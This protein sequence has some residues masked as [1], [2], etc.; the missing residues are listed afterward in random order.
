MNNHEFYSEYYKEL[1]MPSVEWRELSGRIKAENIINILNARKISTVL[2]IGAGTGSILSYLSKMDFATKYYALDISEEAINFI[3]KREDIIGL[4][5][6]NTY[7]G[8][9]L[10]YQDKQFDLVILSHVIE[11][12]HNPAE[13]LIEAARVTRYLVVE[14]PLED[15]LY[16]HIKINLFKSRYRE[17]TGHIQWFT[18]QKF[19]ILLCKTCNLNLLD[20]RMV[21]VPDSAYFFYKGSKRNIFNHLS[22]FIKKILRSIS[23]NI[24]SL[25]LT[26]HCIALVSD[27]KS[28]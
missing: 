1:S 27:L 6:A 24:Y 8:H 11:H 5:D 2:E 23:P 7:D 22:L 3:K 15:N 26:D 17:E 9:H 10:P 18:K 12:L 14:V 21:Y 4:V 13:L 25:L 28:C 16:T 20:T 19:L